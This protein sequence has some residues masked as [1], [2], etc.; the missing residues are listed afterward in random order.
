MYGRR[1]SADISTQPGHPDLKT[2]LEVAA[3]LPRGGPF[4]YKPRQGGVGLRLGY[5]VVN[6]LVDLVSPL[7]RPVGGG[8]L[9]TQSDSLWTWRR[10][11]AASLC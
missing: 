7:E 10:S 4:D 5:D 8:V 11:A 3:S 6:A 1:L 9:C 2:A